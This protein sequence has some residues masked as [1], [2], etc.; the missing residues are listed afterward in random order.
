MNAGFDGF[1]EHSTGGTGTGIVLK[2]AGAH[3]D[4][5]MEDLLTVWIFEVAGG[6]AH[7]RRWNELLS[8]VLRMILVIV[9]LLRIGRLVH[10]LGRDLDD[11]SIMTDRDSSIWAGDCKKITSGLE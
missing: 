3:V 10:R 2:L 9:L 5:L 6:L 7:K 1:I 8:I 4:A 11:W